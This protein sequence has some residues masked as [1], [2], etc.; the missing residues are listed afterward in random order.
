[1]YELHA[2]KAAKKRLL[3]L[4]NAGMRILPTHQVFARVNCGSPAAPDE[5]PDKS[6]FSAQK[7]AN[8]KRKQ[9]L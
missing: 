2:S 7:R 6:Q 8:T 4:K 9:R 3:T 5:S 1:L